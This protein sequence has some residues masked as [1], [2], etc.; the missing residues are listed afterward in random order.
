MKTSPQY[1]INNSGGVQSATNWLLREDSEV[2][3][4]RNARFNDEIGVI[5]RRNGYSKRG[6]SVAT[7]K[8]GLGLHLAKFSTGSKILAAVNDSGDTKTLIRHQD[9]GT[10]AWSNLT[11]PGDIAASTEINMADSLDETYIAGLTPAGDRIPIINVQKDLTTSILR[12]L[13]FAPKARFITEFGG[14]LYALNVDVDGVAYPNRAYRS[15]P[16]LSTITY[17]RGNQEDVLPP[18]TLVDNVPTMT[19][20]STPFGTAAASTNFS[21]FDPWKAFDDTLTRANSW[22]TNTGNATGWIRYDFGSGNAKVITYYSMV[23]CSTNPNFAS[24]DTDIQRTPKTWTLEGSNDASSWTVLDTQTN[25]PIWSAG[26][27]RTY[28]VANTTAYRYYRIN[29]SANNGGT[30]VHI[31]DI[32]FLTSGS[33]DKPLVLSVDSVRYIKPGMTLDIYEKS[34][35]NKRFTLQVATVDKQEDTFTFLPFSYNI[36]SSEVNTSTEEITLPSTANF[37]TGQAIKF[38]STATVPTGLVADT[39]YYAINISSTVIKVA[40]TRDNALVGNA[41]NLTGAGTGTIQ[42]RV[43]YLVGDND[44]IYLTGRYGELY[45]LWNTDYPSVDKA[46]F[47]KIPAGAAENS[48]IIGYGKSNNRL[49]MFTDSSTHTWDKSQLKTL[50]DEIGCANHRTIQKIGDWQLWLDTE[51]RVNAHNDSTGQQE[52]ISKAIQKKY[53]DKLTTSNFTDSAAGVINNQY[54]LHVGTVNDEILRLVYDF[55][56]NTWAVDTHKRNLLQHIVARFTGKRKIY[57]LDHLGNLYVDDDGNLDDTD[58]IP[59]SVKFGR[60]NAGTIDKKGY[61]AFMFIGRNMSGALVN[62]YSEGHGDPVPVGSLKDNYTELVVGRRNIAGRDINVEVS[63]NAQG[64]PV[65][66]EG[67]IPFL[68]AEESRHG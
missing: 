33:T 54:K 2:E 25:A 61:T 31:T 63:L 38:S 20:A 13:L 21:G 66:I 14:S 68:N 47:L 56:S 35:E 60:E 49:F 62:I 52:F 12:N 67:Y 8:R 18:A 29:V 34:T 58:T 11:L 23:A 39:V 42:V 57:F 43:S 4:S 26:E 17:V 59:F 51:G 28:S 32:E 6:D 50:Y 44:E 16:A 10:G 5:L 46:D 45:Y 9:N 36:T 41:I 7:N 24:G 3:D 48:A 19:G 22:F 1:H 55:D 27:K 65:A 30:L 40:T 15:S 53:L 64:D 37:P